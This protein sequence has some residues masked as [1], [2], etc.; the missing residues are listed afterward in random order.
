MHELAAATGIPEN[1]LSKVL[2]ILAREGILASTRGPS[3]GFGFG[4]PP[5]ELR[6]AQVTEPFQLT[7]GP[8]PCVLF[9]APCDMEDPCVAHDRWA[10]MARDFRDFFENTTVA[11]VGLPADRSRE[12]PD[13]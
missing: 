1:Y 11:S 7:G 12:E 2:H 8:T 10:G 3:G 4:I 9:D 5:E 13:T 6:L